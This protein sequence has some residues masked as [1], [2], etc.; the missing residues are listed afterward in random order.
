MQSRLVICVIVTLNPNAGPAGDKASW[1]QRLAALVAVLPVVG[2]FVVVIVGIYGGWA[3]PTEAASIGAAACGQ[4]PI[5]PGSVD[6]LLAQQCTQP[7]PAVGVTDVK[8]LCWRC[9]N[10]HCCESYARYAADAE[11]VKLLGCIQE[12]GKLTDPSGYATC[13]TDCR[14]RH[15]AGLLPTQTR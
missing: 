3:N 2:V 5:G 6:S 12:C 9:D 14:N 10:A 8:A 4:V 11:A 13:N 7:P 1:A 15:S